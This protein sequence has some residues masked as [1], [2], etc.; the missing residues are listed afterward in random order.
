MVTATLFNDQKKRASNIDANLLRSYPYANRI[1]RASQVK[2]QGGKDIRFDASRGGTTHA[3]SIGSFAV[4]ERTVGDFLIQGTMQM[5]IDHSYFSF[6]VMEEEFNRGEY[7]IMNHIDNREQQAMI[8]MVKKIEQDGW[9]NATYGDNLTPQG[10]LYWLPYCAS[11]GFVGT[12]PESYTSVAGINPN[13]HTGW[14]SYG[15]VYVAVTD[16]DLILKVRTALSET[17]FKAPLSSMKVK[18][19][20]TGS[21]YAIYGNLDTELEMENLL[22]QQ[23]DNQGSDLDRYNGKVMLRGIPFEEVPFL[24]S[25]TRDPIL[26]VNWGVT[27]NYVKSGWWNKRIMGKPSSNQPLVVNVDLFCVHQLVM[28]DRRTGGFNISKAA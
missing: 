2:E 18:D 27:K 20:S 12:Y 28:F 1:V 5:R 13:T 6:D 3:S 15:D 19:Y 8:D 14:K 26:G 9:G 24:R 25:N 10:L 23:N 16:A 11:A 17:D 22:K 4:I 21:K 7:E